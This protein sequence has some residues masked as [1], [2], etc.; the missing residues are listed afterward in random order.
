[1]MNTSLV[2]MS[3]CSNKMIS[4]YFDRSFVE[5]VSKKYFIYICIIPDEYLN[6]IH[7][8]HVLVLDQLVHLTTQPMSMLKNCSQKYFIFNTF[9]MVPVK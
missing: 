2:D 3:T 7:D 4:W 9:R 1:M 5:F 8:K 6:H